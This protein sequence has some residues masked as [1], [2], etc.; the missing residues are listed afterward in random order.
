MLN[1]FVFDELNCQN[2]NFL[3]LAC[4]HTR[5]RNEN[6]DCLKIFHIMS[7]FS[8]LS[9]ISFSIFACQ[10]Q[11]FW[12][13]SQMPKKTFSDLCFKSE[14]LFWFVCVCFFFQLAKDLKVWNI[15]QSICSLFLYNFVAII[16]I[17]NGR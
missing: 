7:N 3:Y 5:A 8:N 2:G 14:N 17:V 10:L 9:N 4:V 11:A 12:I 16:H 13:F 1:L 15:N 6:F